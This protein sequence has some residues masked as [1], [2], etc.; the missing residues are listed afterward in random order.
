MFIFVILVTAIASLIGSVIAYWTHKEMKQYLKWIKYCYLVSL[1]FVAGSLFVK[2]AGCLFSIISIFFGVALIV[3]FDWFLLKKGF[4]KSSMETW[5]MV[6]A[7]LAAVFSI[8]ASWGFI[9]AYLVCL[10]NIFYGSLT[11]FPHINNKAK[12]TKLILEQVLYI[13]AGLI[14]Y[15]AL[16]QV[17]LVYRSMFA[18]G[19]FGSLIYLFVKKLMKV[20]K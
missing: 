7:A 6:A 5:I 10:H 3:I 9:A 15:F 4:G 19:L 16:N 2:C 17:E 12:H 1:L 20:K 8:D 11:A 13:V 14:I 18:F